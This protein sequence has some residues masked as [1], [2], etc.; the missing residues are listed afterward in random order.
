MPIID[1][2]DLKII[3]GDS[4]FAYA[5]FTVFLDQTAAAP[6]SFSYYFQDGTASAAD[7]DYN[8]GA[9]TGTIA[10]G[11]NS[12]IVQTPVYGDTLIEGDE[13]FELIVLAGTNGDLAGGAA[14]LSAT[15]TIA[16]NDDGIADG[17]PGDG[18]L[19]ERLTG[20]ASA[21]GTLPTV[22]VRDVV[23]V[24]GDSSFQYARFLVTLDSPAT[25]PVTL[26]YYFQDSTA[27]AGLADYNDGVSSIT[28]PAGQQSTYIQT[29]IYG[30][31]L[32]ESDETFDLI[33]YDATN[34]VLDGNAAVLKATATI[35]DDDGGAPSQSGGIG[36]FADAIAAPVSA[37][38]TL[39]TLDVRD[40]SITEGNSSF[41]YAYFLVMLD[42]PATAP[43]T[44][45]YY[46]QD[47]SGSSALGD[48][49]DGTSSFTIAAGDQS[50]YVRVAVYGDTL[51][52]ADETFTLVV[53]DITNAV[54]AGGA[55]A[56][57]ATGTIINDDSGS[58]S[59]PGGTGDFATQ[60]DGP[61]AA[62][63]TLPTV[64]VSDVSV[65]EGDSSFQYAYFLIT[66]DQPAPTTVTMRYSFNDGS[67]AQALGDYNNGDGTLTINA[68]EESTWVR[69]AVYGDTL[70]EGDEEFTLVLSNIANGVFEGDA[71]AIEATA[72]I[73][74]NDG[75]A[76]SGDGGVGDPGAMV[77]GPKSTGD[78]TL[79]VIDVSIAEGNS[80]FYYAYV[81]L[82]L[83]EPAVGSVSFNYTTLDGTA[84]ENVDYNDVSSTYTFADGS[85]SG[86]IRIP[87]YGDTII[88]GDEEFTLRLSNLTGA[89]FPDGQ[90]TKDA[91]ILI[92]DNDGGGG[93]AGSSDTGPLF[94]YA[95]FGP[96]SGGND[97]ING[98]FENDTIDLM[99]G[100]D[101]YRGLGGNDTITGGAGADYLD[102]GDGIDT[103]DYSSSGS[104]VSISLNSGAASGGDATGDQLVNIENLIGSALNDVLTGNNEGNTIHGGGGADRISG[105]GDGDTLNGDAGNDIVIGG[106]GSDVLN[107]G[108]DDDLLNGNPGGDILNGDGGN[109]TIFGGSDADLLMGGNDDDF[110]FGQSGSDTHYG[111]QGNDVMNGGSNG[112][113]LMGEAGND[114]VYGSVGEDI[115]SGGDGFDFLHGG[116]QG[117]TIDGDDGG[118]TIYGYTGNDI[119]RG[120]DGG[121]F[122]QGGDGSD[123]LN[124]GTGSDVARGAV[125]NDQVYGGQG[126]D[127]LFGDSGQDLLDG[128]L[129]NDVLRGGSGNDTLTGG[130]G[131]DRFNYEDGWGDDIITDF[132]N[133]GQEKI[134]LFAVTGVSSLSD[135]TLTNVGGDVRIQYAGNSILLEN[136]QVSDLDNS[137]FIF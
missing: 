103:A 16:D 13:T 34:A 21:S 92:R 15:A 5:Q 36:G 134:N 89:T 116:A 97:T 96:P 64:R 78:I 8:D 83:S 68:G 114:T 72:T 28:I 81:H 61:D 90:T 38:A 117:D 133:D 129:D 46:L 7:G 6:V 130:S 102:G 135:L 100:D 119:L 45:N 41:Q 124:A 63:A 79:D 3:E 43:V 70:I 71:P 56:L 14:A 111:G 87:I 107:G 17:V 10:A 24:E 105:I 20:P 62:S 53:T 22:S 66:L 80:S 11:T 104:R 95:T 125:G 32:I 25:A 48:Y 4:S 55:S 1:V 27:A 23:Q 57:E 120:G 73:I 75:G 101:S 93:T 42:Q 9:S 19:A 132:A 30:D 86:W 74:D 88:E 50:T 77:N 49:N 51:I 136:L 2:R 52:E 108:A 131:V 127:S 110:I 67:A 126:E 58:P 109:D 137:D 26:K 54:F 60:I 122:L 39:P 99:G 84:T 82:V 59:G 118:D 12:V 128:G 18:A 47:G 112:D 85:Q 29:P 115:L 35:L 123:F 94:N 40:V 106:Q 37:S 76:L 98:S 91:T 33:I 31:T 113:T 69:I 65:I 121:D 44:A